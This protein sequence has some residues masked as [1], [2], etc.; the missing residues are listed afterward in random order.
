MCLYY[1]R[2]I[3]F[4]FLQ[5]SCDDKKLIRVFLFSCNVFKQFIPIL[6]K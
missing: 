4:N 1:F 2:G 3:V 6:T 5:M